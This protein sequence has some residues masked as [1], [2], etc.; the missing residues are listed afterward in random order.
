VSEGESVVAVLGP[1]A[2]KSL[3]VCLHPESCLLKDTFS[4]H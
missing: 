1:G 4:F 3:M 2:L